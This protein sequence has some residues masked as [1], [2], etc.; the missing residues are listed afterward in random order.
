MIS[1]QKI[2]KKKTFSV[3]TAI[4]LIFTILNSAVPIFAATSNQSQSTGIMQ[5]ASSA[6]TFHFFQQSTPTFVGTAGSFLT[7]PIL[8]PSA[9][10]TPSDPKASS[11][12]SIKTPPSFNPKPAALSVSSDPPSVSCPGAYCFAISSSSG[13]AVTQ[14]IG[15]NAVDSFQQFGYDIEPPDQGLCASSQ[16]VVEVLNIGELQVFSAANL[17][18][19]SGI[20]S[21]D[22]LMGLSN[23]GWGSGGDIMCQFDP[24]NGG[25]WFI[26]EF[27]STTPEPASPFSGCFAGV[28]DTCR[29]GIAVS[30][31]SNPMG[32]YY[33]YF[34]DPNK[35]NNDPGVGYLLNDF[36]KIGLTDNALLLFY[37]EFNLNA[38]TYP[39]CP[40]FGCF[41]FN[42]AQEFAFNKIALED[43]KAASQVNVAYENMGNAPNLYPI[44]AES[45]YQPSAASCFEGNFA[46]AVCWYQVIPA[47]TMDFSGLQNN[48]G[49]GYMIG[50]LD[51]FGVGDNRIAVFSWNGLSNLNSQGCSTCS[52][53]TFGGELLTTQV[54]YMDEGLSCL[55]SLGGPCGLGTQAAGLTPLGDLCTLFGLNSSD[56][57]SCPESGI[58]SNGDGATQVWYA[59]GTLWTA[60]STLVVQSYTNGPSEI[61]I[62][63]AYWAIETSESSFSV[64]TQGYVSA[65]HADIEFPSIAASG[66]GQAVMSF[67]LS[68]ADYYPS[69]SYVW[70]APSSNMIF[71]TA[72][73]QSPQDGFTE[74]LGYP[75]TSATRPRWGD[76]G[77]VVFVPSTFKFYFA[78]EYIQYPNCNDQAFLQGIHNGLTCQG[79]RT[80]FANWGTSISLLSL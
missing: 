26:T 10:N 27:V 51:F 4:I 38:S 32:S 44:P 59:A 47:Q 53:I 73:G 17:K 24:S 13:G 20:V 34:L 75:P 76:Y 21:L 30:V 62:G 56:V 66:Y 61:H 36:T 5:A 55:A 16:Y 7:G 31:T 2:L 71:I 19:V 72:K 54:A 48:G 58:A 80:V 37:D 52:G 8:V 23:L 43:G 41:G 35:V 18:P 1:A 45:P 77:Q 9:F 70:L 74:Y 14:P 60:V 22:Q 78:S 12:T 68:G 69:S 67:T 25:H 29:E 3:V 64:I 50:S 40:S 49:S 63:A 33:V 28:Y 65:S 6:N 15:L 11:Y 42:G 79:T 46:G 57:T 39:A